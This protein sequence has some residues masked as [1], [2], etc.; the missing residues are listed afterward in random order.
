[1]VKGHANRRF[2][3]LVERFARIFR[4][5]AHGGGAL[6]VYWRGEPV[7]DV[8]TGYADARGER[9]WER[10]TAA[11]SFSTTKGIASTV[12][13][14]LVDRELLAY[15]EP[16]ATW[17]PAFDTE[18]K[19]H[20]TLRLLMSHQAGLHRI[21]GVVPTAEDLL[22]HRNIADLVAAQT[23]AKPSRGGTGYHG[24]TYGWLL[25]GLVQEVTG[26]SLGEVVQKELVAPLGLDGCFIGT[27]DDQWPRVAELFPPLPE[28]LANAHVEQRIA[29]N[30]RTRYLAEAFFIDGWERLVFD[31]EDRRILRTEMP[32]ANGVFTARSLARVYAALATDGTVDGVE[33]LSRATLKEAGRVQHRGRDYVLGLPMRWRLGYHQAFTAG[34]PASKAFGHYGYGGSGAWADPESGLS[35]AFVTNRLGNVTTPVGDI[36][37]PRL[38]A[39]AL[40]VARNA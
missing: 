32:A 1:M 12:V 25:A 21:R 2:R 28:R 24:L 37:L 3:P 30:R 26:Q 14:R 36:R 29:D 16:L 4:K 22:D 7:V 39:A 31:H 40:G 8:W 19:R 33:V 9:P 5:P 35:L 15:D 6:A 18:D 27:P 17:W 34:R 11:M 20:V 13:H 10:E 38:T 23:P